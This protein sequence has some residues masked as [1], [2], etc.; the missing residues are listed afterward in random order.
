M[1]YFIL[2]IFN[3]LFLNLTIDSF[4][5]MLTSYYFNQGYNKALKE[6]HLKHPN[7][8]KRREK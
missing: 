5:D 3:I 8:L 4:F 2:I 1:I 7:Q 6:H